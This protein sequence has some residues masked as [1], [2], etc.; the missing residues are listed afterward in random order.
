[1]GFWDLSTGEALE[2]TEE[3]DSNTFTIIP[4]KTKC[5]ATIER[6]AWAAMSE[7]S[8][9][10]GEEYIEISWRVSQPNEYKNSVIFQKVR[11]CRDDDKQRDKAIRMLAAIDTI[12]DGGL[13][14]LD[15]RPNDR[16]LDK[17]LKNKR[18]GITVGVWDFNGAQGN[19]VTGV[20]KIKKTSTQNTKPKAEEDDDIPF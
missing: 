10:P 8:D 9:S 12:A 19:F 7:K 4:D 1:M 20:E 16:Q 14:E 3:F 17:A 5:V 2:K 15:D 18:V 6:A 13:M 11:I